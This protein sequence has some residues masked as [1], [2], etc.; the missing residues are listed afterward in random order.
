MVAALDKRVKCVVSQV[1]TI[2][3]WEG[4]LRRI[5]PGDWSGMSAQFD[6]DRMARFK[7]QPPKM[8][9]MVT[10]PIIKTSLLTLAETL[11][12]FLWVN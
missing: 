10:D 3:G 4:M 2:S 7:G 1:P 11:G 9:P 6:Q 5:Q 12:I 8:V